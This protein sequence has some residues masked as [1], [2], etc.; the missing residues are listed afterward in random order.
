MRRFCTWIKTDD[1]YVPG[2]TTEPPKR[3]EPCAKAEPLP[4]HVRA[5][6]LLAHELDAERLN[7][8]HNPRGQSRTAFKRFYS[9]EYQTRQQARDEYFDVLKK[10]E[11][12]IESRLPQPKATK[13]DQQEEIIE[14]F[15]GTFC[16]QSEVMPHQV[17]RRTVL[18]GE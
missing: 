2:V 16:G 1:G 6:I 14:S 9:S 15:G 11:R 17:N 8:N 5:N 4:P 18:V 12:E 10:A 3:I 13:K 7:K